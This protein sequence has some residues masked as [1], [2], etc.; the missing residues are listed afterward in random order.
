MHRLQANPISCEA[1]R[2]RRC[3]IRKD[4]TGHYVGLPPLGNL[5]VVEA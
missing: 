3:G 5:L 1:D 4:A 2:T